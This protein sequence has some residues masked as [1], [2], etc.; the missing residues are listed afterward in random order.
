MLVSL[1]N[2]IGNDAVFRSLVLR[3]LY[4]GGSLL[5]RD[6][7]RVS[8]IA[9]G[10]KLSD[11]RLMGSGVAEDAEK[12]GGEEESKREEAKA[13][14]PVARR[15]AAVFWDGGA[16]STRRDLKVTARP[17][18][19]CHA[20]RAN[21]RLPI[22]PCRAIARRHRCLSYTRQGGKC[23]RLQDGARWLGTPH[24][25]LHSLGRFGMAATMW[26]LL[27]ALRHRHQ[28]ANFR[29]ISVTSLMTSASYA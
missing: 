18:H 12:R 15:C 2:A 16:H 29:R 13:S 23:W 6:S 14:S 20:D 5:S 21:S 11:R 22:G 25:C 9:I 28:C 26:I 1:T 27:A 19:P 3:C 10:S 8:A 7:G 4:P 17:E 24:L